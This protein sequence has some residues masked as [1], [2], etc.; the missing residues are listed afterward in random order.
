MSKTIFS[1]VI[2]FL[3]ILAVLTF[4]LG[5]SVS[6]AKSSAIT[7][8]YPDFSNTARIKLNG[9]ATATTVS[10][11]DTTQAIRLTDALTNQ[12][13]SFYCG[14]YVS[15]ANNRSFSTMFTFNITNP[16]GVGP[17]GADGIVFVINTNT[18]N[19]GALG[20]GMGYSGVTNSLGVEFDTWDNSSDY[21][22][23]GL[24]QNHVA[25][26]INGDT[27][28]PIAKIKEVDIEKLYGV[29]AG[30]FNFG[31]GTSNGNSAPKS[32]KE[33]TYTAWIDYD[34]ITKN[35]SVRVSADSTV[36]PAKAILTQSI[37]LSSST[38]LTTDKVFAGFTGATGGAYSKEY[39]KSWYFNNDYVTASIDPVSNTYIESPKIELT[40]TPST[41]A[42]TS[43]ITATVK[44][45]DGTVAAGIPVS[46][47]VLSGPDA[48]FTTPANVVTD[49]KGTATA[50]LDGSKVPTGTLVVNGA[51]DASKGGNNGTVSI[52]NFGKSNITATIT[53]STINARQNTTYQFTGK[54]FADSYS[55]N[56]AKIKV[57]ALPSSSAGTFKNNGTAV[58][59]GD[60][61]SA[62]SFN[63][64]TFVA[65]SSYVG[66]SP[67]KW[68]ATSDGTTYS[69][70]GN[71]NFNITANHAPVTS[72]ISVTTASNTPVSGTIV[73][74]DTD[75]DALTYIVGTAATK[76]TAS[77]NTTTGGWVYTP[78]LDVVGNDSFAVTVS[79]G[80]GGTATSTVTVTMPATIPTPTPTPTPTATPTPTPTPTATPTATPTPTPTAT[81]TPTPTPTPTATATPAPAK[82]VYINYSY[83]Y[84]YG[85]EQ[86]LAGLEDSV[87]REEAA[88]LLYR[89]LKQD[90]QTGRFSPPSSSSYGDLEKGRW[91]FNAIEYMKF[92]GAFAKTD[93]I[94]PTAPITRGEASKLIAFAMG[95]QPDDSNTISFTDLT[96]SNKYYSYVK[97]LCDVGLLKGYSDNTIRPD[98]QLTRAEYVVMINRLIGRDNSYDIND[99]TNP[100]PDLSNSH[101]A[102]DDAMRASFGFTENDTGKY[103][104]DPAKKLKRNQIDYN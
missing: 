86:G 90:G 75:K 19:L 50:F 89:L 9:T 12:S 32:G 13:G 15:L 6:A 83:A 69:A 99:I 94:K 73:A 44:N 17:S 97:A 43:L 29:P 36:R 57:I 37:N 76:G 27:M 104:N 79:D 56:V 38:T 80:M 103:I 66:S 88:A 59:V 91:S 42:Q 85:Y 52:N 53:D 22:D 98:E 48:E 30:T 4:Q 77:V 3:T 54:E 102:Y 1:R 14:N 21:G 74:T 67:I 46:F 34:G 7:F 39:I 11:Q 61:I 31:N 49:E 23:S 45:S 72:N 51:I 24:S 84:L 78:N 100:Y 33:K 55:S 58:K 18:N 62:S 2:S 71:M 16:G 35:L 25:I 96:E 20:G 70:T 65:A 10:K 101:W 81:P 41:N 8:V 68:Q 28:H 87:K 93:N 63:V 60:I 47:S 26:N 92:I 40:A 64:L 82:R 95:L 5:I